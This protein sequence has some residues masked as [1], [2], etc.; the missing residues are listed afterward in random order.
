[1]II[2]DGVE[3]PGSM[4]L[5]DGDDSDS[6]CKDTE[7]GSG[8]SVARGGSREYEGVGVIVD[9]APVEGCQLMRGHVVSKAEV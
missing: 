2:S 7:D 4:A 3:L 6:Q 5:P 1:M 9:G 8:D